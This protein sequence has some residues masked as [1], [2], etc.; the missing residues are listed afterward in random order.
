MAGESCRRGE[1]LSSWRDL[2]VS[3]FTLGNYKFENHAWIEGPKILTLLVTFDTIGGGGGKQRLERREVGGIFFDKGGPYQRRTHGCW[4]LRFLKNCTGRL[5]GLVMRANPPFA[6]LCASITD[7]LYAGSRSDASFF[8][9][10]VFLNAV[11]WCR[12]LQKWDT[13]RDMLGVFSFG[14]QEIL[15][16]FLLRNIFHIY[17]LEDIINNLWI[18][19]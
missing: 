15:N 13:N 18:F 7:P 8:L 4:S 10:T 1:N 11:G 17:I 2:F 16:D 3:I 5:P 9:L 19:L 14:K 12:D 6:S